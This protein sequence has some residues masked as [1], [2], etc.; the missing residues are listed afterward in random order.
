M[1]LHDEINGVI[2][3]L[4]EENKG[5]KEAQDKGEEVDALRELLESFM[6]GA[7]LVQEHIDQYNER[8]WQR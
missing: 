3:E 7:H 8:R 2:E 4:R 5:L 1:T 6:R